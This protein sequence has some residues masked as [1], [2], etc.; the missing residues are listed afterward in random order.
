MNKQNNLQELTLSEL[1][2]ILNSQD[3]GLHVW[4]K[5]KG[6]GLIPAIID[7][8]TEDGIVAVWCAPIGDDPYKECDYGTVWTALIDKDFYLKEKEFLC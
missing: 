2:Y 1:K 8:T 6:F 4:V 3:F 5:E 7:E